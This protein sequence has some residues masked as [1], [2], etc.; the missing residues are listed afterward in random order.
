MGN[1]NFKVVGM[2][3]IYVE[4]NK[5]YAGLATLG[6]DTGPI[7][8]NT[9]D[10]L[11]IILEPYL[12]NHL[13]N[14]CDVP[15]T[16]CDTALNYFYTIT[17]GSGVPPTMVATF[18][19]DTPSGANIHVWRVAGAGE[20][21]A[22]KT[23]SGKDQLIGTTS[24]GN[25]TFTY[26]IGDLFK[27]V[28]VPGSGYAFDKYCNSDP[29]TNSGT[30]TNGIF[31]GTI[32][33]PTGNL[34]TYFKASG[35]GVIP[36]TAGI[37]KAA[38]FNWCWKVGMAT[39]SCNMPRDSG[40]VTP[41]SAVVIQ[42][43]IANSGYVGKVRCVL[44]ID[45]S[46]I[47]SQDNGALDTFPTGPL[48]S[49]RTT[50]TMPNKNVTLSAEAYS[51]DGSTWVLTDSKTDI[52]STSG[53]GCGNVALDPVSALVD[54][55]DTKTYQ[56]TMTATVTPFG[57]G[58]ASFPV[59]FKS[60]SGTVLGNCNT[61][62]VTG[63]CTFVWDYNTI[64]SSGGSPDIT[65]SDGTSGYYVTAVVGTPG[66]VGACTSTKTTIVIGKL[67]KQ[68]T[69][70][71]SVKDANT[72]SLVSGANVTVATAGGPSQSK[73]TNGTG[74]GSSGGGTA[75]F[76]VDE[77]TVGITITKTGYNN[78]TNSE[79]VFMDKTVTYSFVPT[80]AVP[81]TGSAQ[82]VSV[83][84]GAAIYLDDN[85]KSIGVTPRT[86]D[87]ISA[88]D[89]KFTLKLA[90]YN[91]SSGN[92]TVQ[93]GSLAYAYMSMTVLTPT[94]GS[95]NITSHPVMGAEVYIDG[96]DYKVTSSGATLITDIPPGTHKYTLKMTGYKDSTSTFGINAG[97]T[98]FIDAEMVP[99]LTT[100]SVE[101]KSTPSGAQVNVDGN[102][103][104]K[105]TP[106][107]VMNLEPGGHS[108]KLVLVGYQDGT[109]GF[110]INAGE[111]TTVDVIL[112]AVT[113][114]TGTLTITSDPPNA[115]VILDGD[116]IG[117]VTPAIV[118]DLTAEKH[119]YLLKLE[120]YKDAGA[121]FTIVEGFTKTINVSLEQIT[122]GTGGDG[123]G[124]GIGIGEVLGAAAAGLFIL[125][126]LTG[127]DK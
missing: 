114:T 84:S 60:G 93:S 116:D 36:P 28:A 127:S 113:P 20:V 29:C 49:V 74:G 34:Y 41:G 35:G 85:T 54:L 73:V 5:S 40:A 38:V 122:G 2:G 75:T 111:V 58:G 105:A 100:G 109:G 63:K 89:H 118:K 16:E 52:I 47:L 101:I 43:D 82:F 70:S 65:F 56:I 9:G 67:I 97:L 79:Y 50:Y 3:Q 125:T 53:A 51:W 78:Y 117:K 106:A 87:G 76:I 119:T 112:K 98:T 14:F 39:G 86:V 7:N 24:G 108:Y 66:T 120:G 88:G 21:T 121:V 31:T 32:T 26:N 8:F 96:T 94:T 25:G 103:T 23:V 46:Q 107:S 11:G 81:T 12:G 91:D 48:W 80:P 123:A 6:M 95:L 1:I 55:A 4:K 64:K 19:A 10:T 68:W 45:G 62:K 126:Y 124:A 99:L 90:G 30:V 115:K 13:V 18:G 71:V 37:P 27:I 69:L 110:N 59:M 104:S 102:D 42:A 57:T 22:Y 61:D 15:Q 72:G 44:K 92:V 33:V 17:D 77:G 83:P